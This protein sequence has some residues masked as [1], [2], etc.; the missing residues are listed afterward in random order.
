MD[1]LVDALGRD[2]GRLRKR[3]AFVALAAVALAGGAALVGWRLRAGSDEVAC[4]GGETRFSG[5]WDDAM[6]ARVA[7]SFAASKLVYADASAQRAA[8][9]LDD[10]RARWV[11]MHGDACRATRSGEQSAHVLDLRMACLD[12]HLGEVRALTTILASASDAKTI[13]SAVDAASALGSLAGCA[14]TTALLQPDAEPTEPARRARRAELRDRLDEL[15]AQSSLGRSKDI[16]ASARTLVAD[17][18]AS[19]D[20]VMLAG[21]L[22][23]Q[24]TAELQTGDLKHAE[25][26]LGEAVRRA[27]QLND[28]DAFVEAAST[29]ADALQMGGLTKG[30]EALGV[31]RLAKAVVD[32]SRDPA[33]AITLLTN[34]ANILILLAHKADSLPILDDAGERCRRTLGEDST[35]YFQIQRMRALAL[36]ADKKASHSAYEA[37]IARAAKTFGP[38]HPTTIHTRLEQCRSLT[39]SG[40]DNAAIPCY[41]AVLPDAD[42]VLGRS[43]RTNI[44]DRSIFALSLLHLGKTDRAMEVYADAYARIPA[45]AWT[46]QWSG[47]ADVGHALGSL[48]LERGDF[49]AALAHCER[50]RAATE[51]QHGL[52]EMNT[53]IAGAQLGLGDSTHALAT[54]ESVRGQLDRVAPEDAAGWRFTYARVVWAAKHDATQAREVAAAAR[55][56]LPPDSRAKLDAWLAAIPR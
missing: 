22:R 14:D 30:R 42:R 6:R 48:E 52:L 39:I 13:A 9:V 18:R 20:T 43:D 28:A 24:G 37:L 33:V 8:A 50:A 44:S 10:Y 32:D 40:D 49:A 53:C 36:N 51:Q 47:A 21:A 2:P 29:F 16:L 55:S 34:E 3:T 35:L 26:T 17:A 7:G 5:V 23:V 1:A 45:D 54:L 41:E 25:A 38:L 31:V 46:D 56:A 19:S 15:R 4:T 27:R 11:A 12:R